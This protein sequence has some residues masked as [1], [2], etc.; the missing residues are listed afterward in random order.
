ME[1]EARTRLRPLKRQAE[2]AELHERLER[3]VL[4]ARWEL[5]RDAF[6]ART[7]ELT[8]AEAGVADAR[9]ARDGIESELAAMV[10]RR[11]RAERALQ[12]RAERH[13]ALSRRV[14][15]ARSARERLGL[16]A[17]QAGA[18]AGAL[19]G[20]IQRVELELESLKEATAQH[21][22][23]G[24][25]EQADRSATSV[26][27][28][29]IATLEAELA[30]IEQRRRG[31]TQGQLEELEGAR[32][33][34]R[35]RVQ[36]LEGEL[37]AA[38]QARERAE[39]LIEKARAGSVW[40]TTW[41]EVRRVLADG[42]ERIIAGRDEGER[43]VAA[44]EVAAQ[45]ERVA[46]GVVEYALKGVRAAEDVR[47]EA[48]AAL[49]EAER[50]RAEAGEQQD[51]TEWLIEQRRA[52]S[53]QG[54]LAVR[55]AKL[56]GELDAERRQAE[57]MA[58][59]RAE[60]LGR[61]ERLRAQH[62]TDTALL[63]LTTRLAAALADAAEAV[64]QRIVAFEGELARDH[65]T[66]EAMAGEL[67]ECAGQEADIQARLRGA[68]EVVTAAEVAA[69]RLRDQ[70]G[71]A[72]LEVRGIAARLGLDASEPAETLDEEQTQA[73]LVRVERLERRREQLGP[74]NPLAQ[75]EHSE[76]VAHVEEMEGRRAD[77]ETALRELRTL[78]ADTDRQIQETFKETF[79]RAAR[80]FEELLGDVFP[81]GSGRLRLVREEQ[82]PRPVLGGQSLAADA[83]SNGDA[84]T[85][86]AGDGDAIEAAA[87][88][89]AE[90]LQNN[91]EDLLGVEIEITPAGKATKRLSLLS[92]GE[93]S[94]TA[95]AFLFAVFLARP[96]PFYV[97]DEV[98]AALDDLNLDRFLA[99]LRRYSHRA[100]FIVITHQKRTME[101]ADSL[102]GVS[103]GGNGVSK[104][105]SRRLPAEQAQ[106]SE[107]AEV[108]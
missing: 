10:E 93:K 24:H 13:D 72:E 30:E 14:Y 6:Q 7:A 53:Q 17:E 1:R 74:V 23:D 42:V 4:E 108:A 83:S 95:L 94:M 46:R 90:S 76:A 39:E 20:R 59:E 105:L 75:Q 101:A 69:Q 104:V 68:G 106:E 25:R 33:A 27:V 40:S 84:A 56:Q 60:R 71:E 38:R 65:A 78:I 28:A 5:A 107:V 61:A 97:L 70:A 54:P 96:C 55:R 66:G 45:A 16:R 18:S 36:A 9:R 50:R 11:G 87:E 3:Q 73:L 57:H 29:R 103:M 22:Q 81:G 48:E 15:D 67:R 63:P 19:T 52:A 44:G 89:E 2:A 62:A 43:R 47:E 82:A 92:G 99:L 100:Q 26:S 37:L 85:V 86:D 34:E 35:A 31:E 64:E 91:E 77:L 12:E 79:E 49:R 80:N 32:E 88:A 51:R 98:E 8:E 21:G 102:Y 41:E 58:R